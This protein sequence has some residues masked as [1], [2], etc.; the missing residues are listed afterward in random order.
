MST[1]LLLV[2]ALSDPAT[3]L[4]TLRTSFAKMDVLTFHVRRYIS[5][6]FALSFSLPSELLPDDTL[7]APGGQIV[8]LDRHPSKAGVQ[9]CGCLGEEVLVDTA[10]LIALILC[11]CCR[12]FLI[13]LRLTV[14]A[15]TGFLIFAPG[16]PSSYDDS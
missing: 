2:S 9:T 13:G 15:G 4:P 11:N 16:G 7:D 5:L 6:A 12:A 8:L 14:Y 3:I 1:P 10:S